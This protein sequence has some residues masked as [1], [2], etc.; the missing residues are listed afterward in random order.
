MT[1]DNAS[2]KRIHK[3]IDRVEQDYDGLDKVVRGNGDAGMKGEIIDLKG[4]VGRFEDYVKDQKLW[5]RTI[6]IA[7]IIQLLISIFR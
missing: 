6:G 1:I 3:R 4:R 7:V 5:Y 2:A